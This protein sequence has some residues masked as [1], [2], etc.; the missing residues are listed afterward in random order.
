[1]V[2]VIANKP[3]QKNGVK[4]GTKLKMRNGMDKTAII[5][6][7]NIKLIFGLLLKTIN[8]K[9]VMKKIAMSHRF[10]IH[11]NIKRSFTD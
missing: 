11:P 5:K 1:M 8:D 10:P 6:L 9:K 2:I 3:Q 7:E 4:S